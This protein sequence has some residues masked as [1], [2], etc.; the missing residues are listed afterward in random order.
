MTVIKQLVIVLLIGVFSFYCSAESLQK[1]TTNPESGAM[2]WET[3]AHG[4]YLSMTQ[5]L[6]GRAQAFYVG[7]GF[8]TQEIEPYTSSCLFLTVLRNDNVSGALDFKRENLKVTQGGKS[9][10]L[11]LVDDWMQRLEDAK[12]K[13]SAMIAF[14]W[15][16]FPVEQVF[17]PGGDWNQGMLSIGLP[18]EN[19]FDA[20][21]SWEI[22]DKPLKI[23]LEGVECAKK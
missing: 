4:V 23:K 21:I 14:R 20:V 19:R 1:K 16:Q 3:V 9:H 2:A 15:A 8:T 10:S 11:L 7:R 13:K 6:P 18:P 5:V 17:E 12:S 22:E